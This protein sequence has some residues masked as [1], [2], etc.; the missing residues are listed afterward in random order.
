M[1]NACLVYAISEH[2][3]V[4]DGLC[5]GE[6]THCVRLS[7]RTP[8]QMKPCFERCQPYPFPRSGRVTKTAVSIVN[9]AQ[10]PS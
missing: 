4:Q 8:L 3:Y 7:A 6:I 9:S 2:K 5:E 10:T 1:I